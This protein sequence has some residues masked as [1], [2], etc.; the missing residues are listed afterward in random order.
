MV[1]IAISSPKTMPYREW[2]GLKSPVSRELG[3]PERSAQQGD[4]RHSSG[5]ERGLGRAK[6]SFEIMRHVVSKCNH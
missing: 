5:K 4:E 3:A 6:Y 1:G 2:Q